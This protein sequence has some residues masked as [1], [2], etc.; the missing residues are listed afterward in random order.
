MNDWTQGTE[1]I[2]YQRCSAC[3]HVWYFRRSF[4]P[5]CGSVDVTT[6]QASGTGTV[7]AVTDV[8]RAPSEQL[9]AHAPYAIALIDTDEGFRMMAHVERGTGIGERVRARFVAFGEGIVPQFTR[10]LP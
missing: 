7:Y 10:V 5:H 3:S 9:R 4:C 8:L 2:V 6:L 1:G